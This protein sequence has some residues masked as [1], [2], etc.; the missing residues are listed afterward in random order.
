MSLKH[1]TAVED[2]EGTVHLLLGLWFFVR[3]GEHAVGL[4]GAFSPYCR[5]SKMVIFIFAKVSHQV[6]P[7]TGQSDACSL[8]MSHFHIISDCLE[9]RQADIKKGTWYHVLPPNG[10]PSVLC[11]V[12]V[13]YIDLKYQIAFDLK[14]NRLI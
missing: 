13:P 11:I 4:C 8:L 5:V 10:K 14:V 7:L 2:V 3:L 9:P 12:K 1:N 6:T